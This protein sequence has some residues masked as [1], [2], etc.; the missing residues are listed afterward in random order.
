MLVS[1]VI[2]VGDAGPAE[3][4]REFLEQL[5]RQGQADRLFAPVMSAGESYQVKVVEAGEFGSISALTPRMTENGAAALRLALQAEPEARFLA[6][7]RPCEL[8]AVVELAKRDQIAMDRLVAVG[9]DCLSTYEQAYAESGGSRRRSEPDWLMRDSLRLAKSGQLATSGT[10]LA[11][12]LCDRPAPDYRAADIM[13]GLVG[14]DTDEKILILA[15]EGDDAR[16][17]LETLTTRP[18]TER[19]SVERE[20]TLWRLMERRKEAADRVLEQL[21]LAD[22]Y[23]GIIS[24]YMHKCT[25]CGD[26]IDACPQSAEALRAA[27]KVGRDRFID[28][29]LNESLRMASCSGCGMCQAHCPE[30]IPLCA[31]SRAL[32]RQIQLRMHY[33]PG[34]DIKEPLPWSN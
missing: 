25:L 13:I 7:L 12:Q 18:A 24:G 15:E 11:C 5:I 2:E 27:L 20:V 6:V 19:E 1:R 22:A 34:R 3:T 8:R 21:G 10:R 32:S 4:V 26:C 30:G 9:I 23:P 16:F 17:G 28:T 33:I 14:V 29:L 31:I